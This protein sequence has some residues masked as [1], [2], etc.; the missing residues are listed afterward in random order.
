MTSPRN[1]RS[2]ARSYAA[3]GATALLMTTLAACGDTS[4]SNADGQNDLTVGLAGA[5]SASTPLY[6]P[7]VLGYFEDE[8]LDVTFKTGST[9][10]IQTLVAGQVD[11]AYIGSSGATV[12]AVEGKPTS[13]TYGV[14]GQ[15]TTAWTVG[16]PD[17]KSIDECTRFATS[18]VGTA[19]Y[20][21]AS[22]IN[23]GFKT[24]AEI[25]SIPDQE[26]R[27]ASMETGNV[28]CMNGSAARLAALVENGRATWLVRPDEPETLPAGTSLDLM[29]AGI[30]SMRDNAEKK[31]PD[32]VAFIRAM[33]RGAEYVKSHTV[34]EIAAVL[35]DHTDFAAFNKADLA[36]GIGLDLTT[37]YP[38]GGVVDKEAW[39]DTLAWMDQAG[40]EGFDPQAPEVS[41]DEIIDMS[42]YDEAT[43]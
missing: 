30:V 38:N 41:F 11:L 1:R 28:N 25:V 32:M 17:V 31:R 20:A 9:T 33:N 14:V 13:I 2:A 10:L 12:P 6:V 40:L 26:A 34:E 22:E 3:A 24:G 37:M 36:L 16:S 8:G 39:D 21:W 35:M 23:Q 42:Y 4:S 5:N 15:G 7:L 19:P 18:S 27:V 43:K 29:E